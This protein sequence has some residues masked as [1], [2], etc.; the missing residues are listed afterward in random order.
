M[1]TINIH[2]YR[3]FEKF[4]ISGLGRINLLVGAN[5]S[6]KTSAL[7]A[8]YF[9]ASRGEPSSLLQSLTQRGERVTTRR[10]ESGFRP[11]VEFDVSHLFFGHESRVGAKFQI[12]SKNDGSSRSINVSIEELADKDLAEVPP[13]PRL[14]P[15]RLALRIKGEPHPSVTTLRL[16]RLD[17]I[18]LDSIESPRR[19]RRRT[20]DESGQTQFIS[21]ES[22]SA[23]DL[24]AMWDSVVLTDNENLVLRALQFLDP[25]I[26]RVAAQVGSTYTSARGGFIVKQKG[27]GKPIP[28]GSLGGGMWRMLALAITITQC[29][30]GVLL[31]DEIDTGLHYS[32]LGNMW[33]LIS[34]A[35][36]QFEVQVFAT[37]H[38]SDCIKS[39]AS[40]CI[41][42]DLFAS[43]PIT[44]QRIEFG[45]SIAT[46][47]SPEEIRIAADSNIEVR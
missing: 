6:G 44:L 13:D 19:I 15:S 27:P 5:N 2:G 17:A 16:S 21:P 3:G 39:F 14:P 8:I 18:N 7:E 20:T 10:E 22:L 23:G 41:E 26:E 33:R 42:Q 12:Q 4:E 32:V 30:G 47:Y 37:T 29:R 1:S 31:V 35:A 38:S 46:R 9:L 11:N 25:S 28:I 24:A 43:R 45:K 34:D 36:V 40:V